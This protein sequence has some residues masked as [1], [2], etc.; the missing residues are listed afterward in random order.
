MPGR[1]VL[2]KT[3]KYYDDELNGFE[4]AMS[5]LGITEY[6][7]VTVMETDLRF[8]RN[9]LYPPVRGLYFH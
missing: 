4:Q 6:D 8:F 7:I 2:H 3:S 1:L 5:E 9:N